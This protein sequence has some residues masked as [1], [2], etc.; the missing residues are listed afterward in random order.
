MLRNLQFQGGKLTVE[1]RAIACGKDDTRVRGVPIRAE[2]GNSVR[3]HTTRDT[4]AP[5]VIVLVLDWRGRHLRWLCEAI[6][7]R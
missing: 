6:V 1:L 5:V 4:E 3:Q 2:G 7:R